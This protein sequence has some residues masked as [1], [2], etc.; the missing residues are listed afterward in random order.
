MPRA[1]A[2]REAPVR[3]AAV[4]PARAGGR[5]RPRSV[6]PPWPAPSR[7]DPSPIE[8]AATRDTSSAA[9]RRLRARTHDRALPRARA[10]MPA[11]GAFA[12][13][14]THL[15]AHETPEHLVC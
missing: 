12:V 3:A 8:S 1:P 7:T 15:R 2:G 13:S 5:T 10:T 11:A 6:R 14:Y 4:D 9:V